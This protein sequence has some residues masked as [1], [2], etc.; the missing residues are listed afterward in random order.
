MPKKIQMCLKYFFKKDS[1]IYE[2]VCDVHT[3]T[4][5]QEVGAERGQR[6]SEGENPKRTPH[7]AES[8]AQRPAW[9]HY[10]ETMRRAE[11]KSQP[12]N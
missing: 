12:P 7:Q 8:R 5:V 10:P 2:K 1:F 9:P 3:H 6:V 11:T 4:Q